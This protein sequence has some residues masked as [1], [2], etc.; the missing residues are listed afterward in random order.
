MW[1]VI[2]MSLWPW[3]AYGA[4]ISEF[5]SQLN[6]VFA[7]VNRPLASFL[8]FSDHPL[9][10]PLILVVMLTG[11]VVLTLRMKFVNVRLFK[12]AID[13][14]RGR[15][16]DPNHVGEVTHFQA[17]TS[18]LSATVGLGNIA[19]VA[20]AVSLGGPGAVFW[21]WVV[22]FFG[23]SMKF[24]SCTFAQMYRRV[25][26]QGRVLGGPMVYLEEGFRES[27]VIGSA[28]GLILARIFAVMAIFASFGG[29]NLFQANQ[30]F[31]LLETEFVVFQGSGLIVGCVLAFFVGIVLVGGVTRIGEVTSKLVPLMCGLYCLGCLAVLSAN[32]SAIPDAFYEIFK[33][34]WYPQAMWSGGFIGVLIQGIRRASFSNEAGVGSA[35]IAHAAAK[36]DEP[37][38]E[39]VV[40]MLGPFID[41]HIVCTMTALTVIVSGAY[42]EP[43]LVGK[44]AALTAYAFSTVGPFLASVL[45]I[46]AVVFAYSTIL[47]WSYYGEKG[48]EYLFG[49]KGILPYRI[50]YVLVVIMGPVVSLQNVI[51]FSDMMLLSMAFPNIIGMLFLS[52]QV[53]QK[54]ESYM[55]TYKKLERSN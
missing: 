10:L 34:A 53:S 41:T 2:L 3:C 8:F 18:A 32:I 49:E 51:D 27:G 33:Q 21:L 42:L 19:G 30:A 39:G 28:F 37:V 50:L 38:R 36:T 25:N 40:G 54:L 4:Q 22:A 17:L 44:G 35:A 11:G 29:G 9:Q 31:E 14:V 46:I 23:M 6:N 13:V 26:P 7:A 52:K 48:V 47:S 15:F 5:E 12:H 20:I 45:S 24:T 1:K 55:V 16:D 43:A